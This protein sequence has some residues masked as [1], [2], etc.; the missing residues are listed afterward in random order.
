M[1]ILIASGVHAQ[2]VDIMSSP[3]VV[4]SGARALGM[5]GAFIAIADDATAASWNPGG[6]TQLERPEIS[7]VYDFKWNSERFSSRSHREIEGTY[8]VSFN[9]FNYAS[10]VYPIQRTIAGRN[11]VLSL[12][13]QRQYDFDRK[14][15]FHYRDVLG[16]TGGNVAGFRSTIKYRQ[17]GQ[18]SSLSPAIGF[19]LTQ[20]LSLGVTFNIWD[21]SLLP[22]NEWEIQLDERRVFNINGAMNP[23]S[24][25]R[26]SMQ[27]KYTGFRGFNITV[28]A[29]YRATERLQFGMVYHSKFTAS[30]NYERRVHIWG[31]AGNGFVTGRRSQ[32]IV[33]PSAIG[34]GA[35][36][37]FP[38][39]KLIIA[40]DVTRREWDQF[41]I[42]DPDNRQINRRRISGVTGLPPDQNDVDP[43]YTVRFGVEYVFVNKKKAIQNLLPSVRAGAF[44]DPEPA[45]NRSDNFFGLGRGDGKPDDYFGISLGA[46]VLIKNRVNIDLAYVYRWGDGV[47]RDTFGFSG[48]SAEVEQHTVYISTVV[49]F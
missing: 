41:I 17:Q 40:M 16:L 4:G 28:G 6:L 7:L 30:V 48:T 29:L 15:N 9:G 49:Y 19:E 31:G 23:W 8:N 5:G 39:D 10:G 34:F 37:R 36:Y 45:S 43:V 12:N 42:H 20:R 27:E 21:E 24:W 46:G 13:Y 2:S 47:R 18:L 44:Y 38:N 14:L 35:S 32:E 11:L 3:N 33:F 25:T 26:F 1:L 22:E